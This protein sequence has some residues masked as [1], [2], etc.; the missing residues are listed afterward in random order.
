MPASLFSRCGSNRTTRT[1]PSPLHRRAFQG[2]HERLNPATTLQLNVLSEAPELA[3]YGLMK[4]KLTSCGRSAG[5]SIELAG[6]VRSLA[7]YSAASGIGSCN[8]TVSSIASSQPAH[9]V[10][11]S[12]QI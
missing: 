4:P 8:A 5:I 1:Y 9:S 6:E 12:S 7:G 2:N 10:A 3:A 11:A